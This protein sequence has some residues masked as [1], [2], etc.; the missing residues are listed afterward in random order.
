MPDVARRTRRRRVAFITLLVVCIAQLAWWMLDEVRYTASVRARL[1][2]ADSTN[3]AAAILLRSHGVGWS[4]I[5]QLY[6]SLSISPDSQTISIA[7]HVLDEVQRERFRRLNRFAWEGAFFLAV[8]IAAIA[9]VSKALRE[10]ADL[11]RRQEEFLAAVSHE[12]QSPL[13]SLRLSLETLSL[14]DPP[15]ARRAELIERSL[16][17][18]TRLERMIGNI[19]DASRMSAPDRQVAV[20][21]VSLGDHVSAVLAELR[22][23]AAQNGTT[24]DA[25]VPAGL[26][27]IATP[28]CVRTI[29][30]NLVHNAVNATRAGG[31]ISVSARRR[32]GAVELVVHDTGV[33]FPPSERARLFEKFYRVES[34]GRW[35]GTGLGLFLVQRCATADGA[36]VRA[37]SQGP[38]HGATFTVVWP[39]GTTDRN[40]EPAPQTTVERDDAVTAR[41]RA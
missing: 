37:H 23:T 27:V 38:G 16:S 35:S 11:R 25:D 9:V 18:I 17:D 26:A 30:R 29:V 39:A 41:G 3:V 12:L 6:P 31:S 40:A 1:D 2:A 10:E 19:L 28:E 4:G 36:S 7:P 32:D 21:H 15:P 14:R 22:D 33:G 34:D 13:A 5:A 8:L 20:E 24:I